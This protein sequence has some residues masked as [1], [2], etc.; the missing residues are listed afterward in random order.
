MSDPNEK[1]VLGNSE[2]RSPVFPAF[3]SRNKQEEMPT[4]ANAWGG[5]IWFWVVAIK[6]FLGNSETYVQGTN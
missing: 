4:N 2:I 3:P 1:Y 6:R 5:H